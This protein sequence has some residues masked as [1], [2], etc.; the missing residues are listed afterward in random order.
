MTVHIDFTL[1][2]ETGKYYCRCCGYESSDI[3]DFATGGF[4]WACAFDGNEVCVHGEWIAE[5]A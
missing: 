3:E 2:N 1:K 5:S 4:C